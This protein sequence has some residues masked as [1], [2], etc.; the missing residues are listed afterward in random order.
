MEE[1]PI[2]HFN[3]ILIN[4]I[5][6]HFLYIEVILT[7]NNIIIVYFITTINYLAKNSSINKSII[8]S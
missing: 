4:N 8:V 7:A 2:L 5:Y 1:F 6:K 3:T